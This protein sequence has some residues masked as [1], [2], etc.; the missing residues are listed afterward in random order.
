MVFDLTAEEK[1]G[2]GDFGEGAGGLAT[3]VGRRPEGCFLGGFFLAMV[4]GGSCRRDRR[5]W[6]EKERDRV[7]REKI[8]A[9]EACDPP[10]FEKKKKEG[11]MAHC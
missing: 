8:L 9:R 6:R 7:L 4:A 2:V 3:P 11:K 5:R 1:S 10:S